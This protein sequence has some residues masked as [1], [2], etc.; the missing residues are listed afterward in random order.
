MLDKVNMVNLKINISKYIKKNQVVVETV[1]EMM[2]QI[3]KII[4]M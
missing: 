4:M 2:D 3:L 1:E